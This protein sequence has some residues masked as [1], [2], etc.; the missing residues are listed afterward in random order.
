MKLGEQFFEDGSKVIHK[1]TFDPNPTLKKA[2]LMRSAGKEDFGESK[3]IGVVPG[4]LFHLWLKE[5][6][7]KPED[8][9]AARQVIDRKLMSGEFSNF[10]VWGGT[11]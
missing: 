8:H 1:R 6:G 2:E 3:C 9:E 11:Y 4:W 5:A 10:R 7:V